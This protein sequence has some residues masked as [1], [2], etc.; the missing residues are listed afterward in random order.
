MPN[1]KD[2]F[3]NSD[4]EKLTGLKYKTLYEYRNRNTLPKPDAYFGRTPVWK[5]STIETWNNSRNQLEV[6]NETDN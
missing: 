2:W 1:T 4:I 5:R 3:T 6:N